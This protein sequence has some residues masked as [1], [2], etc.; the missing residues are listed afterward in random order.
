MFQET[1]SS[2][3]HE[4]R[5]QTVS[6]QS[7]SSGDSQLE[8]FAC[9]MLKLDKANYADVPK[10]ERTAYK[11]HRLMEI[12]SYH[13]AEIK[14]E[15]KR[16]FSSASRSEKNRKDLC[17]SIFSFISATES[18]YGRVAS[19]LKVFFGSTFTKSYVC[20]L[21]KAGEVCSKFPI[22]DN[23]I[24]IDKLYMLSRLDDE[25]LEK[26]LEKSGSETAILDKPINLSSRKE[27]R[28]HL[29]DYFPDVF[30]Q[31]SNRE[32]PRP[33]QSEVIPTASL[34]TLK[35]SLE[36]HQQLFNEEDELNNLI[37]RCLEV[38]SKRTT[39]E[40]TTQEGEHQ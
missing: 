26:S 19:V 6:N 18:Q 31:T 24:D 2:L 27:L 38:L 9:E 37:E 22:L 7:R 39:G 12:E 14:D 5:N 1:I 20:R 36:V 33:E 35:Q 4:S 15:I 29:Q 21:Y 8:S 28:E 16:I 17:A 3:D 10:A 40:T 30:P 34:E 13:S 32:Q 25:T 23:V 11:E